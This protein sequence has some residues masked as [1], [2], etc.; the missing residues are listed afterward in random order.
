M[1]TVKRFIALRLAL[2]VAMGLGALLPRAVAAEGAETETIVLVRH[3]EKPALG[4]GQLNCQGLNRALALPDVIGKKFGRPDAIFA[5]DPAQMKEDLG[6]L[7]NYVR[8]LATIEP[9][10]IVF[11]LPIDAS[12]G[13]S[14]LDALR[15]R[16]ELPTY[17]SALLLVAWE[18]AAIVQ[19]ARHLIADHGGDPAVVPD[20]KG[21]DF[22]SIYVVRITRTGAEA[23]VKFELLHEGLDGQPEVCPAHAPGVNRR[24]IRTPFRG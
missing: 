7:Y 16:L 21:V 6:Q 24:G 4:L 3:G 9:T 18:H 23:A 20:W 14:N 19:V 8:P 22:D 17:R 1:F 2:S 15:Q 13:F 10:A 11:G 5:P 12:I